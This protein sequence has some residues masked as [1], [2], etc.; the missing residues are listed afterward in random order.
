MFPVLLST[1]I[2]N[3]LKIRIYLSWKCFMKNSEGFPVATAHP[4]LRHWVRLSTLSPWRLKFLFESL[5]CS[6]ASENH[7]FILLVVSSPK[8]LRLKS[9]ICQKKL[10]G[11]LTIVQTPLF[12]GF[13]NLTTSFNSKLALFSNFYLKELL[14][15]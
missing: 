1:Q 13:R 10:N 4:F 8:T 3:W 11:E 6:E 7:W 15:L 2:R 9:I 12:I 14:S 5:P